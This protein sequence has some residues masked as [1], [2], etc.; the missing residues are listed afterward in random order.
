MTPI[1]FPGCTTTIAKNQPQYRPLPCQE[2]H[3]PNDTVLICWRLS[4]WER[5]K[6]MLTGN[7]WQYALRF[8]NPMM[9]QTLTVSRIGYAYELKYERIRAKALRLLNM[10]QQALA[11]GDIGLAERF[12]KRMLKLAA[13]LETMRA[14]QPR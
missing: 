4:L 2:L 9:P 3:D 6:I 1:N 11:I 10:C 13:K 5:I 14:N 8:G 7:L 12:E